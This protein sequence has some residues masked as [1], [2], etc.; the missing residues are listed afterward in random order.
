MINPRETFGKR[1]R[2]FMDEA[3]LAE[4]AVSNPDKVN[5]RPWYYEIRGKYGTVYVYGDNM[6]AV[7]ITANRVKGSI[8]KAYGNILCLYLKAEDESIFLFKPDNLEIVAGLIKARRKRQVTEPER[9]RLRNIGRFSHYKK[10]YTA[11]I[12]M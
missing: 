9:Q 10:Q 3:W 11:Q 12:P 7:S 8:K 6:L 1:Y 5:D 4:D 2:I